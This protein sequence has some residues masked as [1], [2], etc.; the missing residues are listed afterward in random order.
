MAARR[1]GRGGSPKARRR[2][3]PPRA[4]GHR[5]HVQQLGAAAGAGAVHRLRRHRRRRCPAPAPRRC[6]VRQ[7]QPARWG[8]AARAAPRACW[9]A[10]PA[11]SQAPRPAR[12][13]VAQPPIGRLAAQRRRVARPGFATGEQGDG[14]RRR[15]AALR[16]AWSGLPPQQGHQ[17]QWGASG[18]L[19]PSV[20]C[21]GPQA[22]S[23]AGPTAERPSD[24]V[25]MT[26]RNTAL[27]GRYARQSARWARMRHEFARHPR[28]RPLPRAGRPG[29]RPWP[30]WGPTIKIERPGG[31]DDTRSW[32][33]PSWWATTAPNRTKAAYY[34]GANPQQALA[35]LRHRPA[36]RA[37]S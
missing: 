9:P 17:R 16:V 32:G 2:R 21:V 12:S 6:G 33:R 18:H 27:G 1:H 24:I 34:L 36:R 13:P 10:W 19:A 3:R 15:P 23:I 4:W 37:S 25:I 5:P 31:G 14:R 26:A 30:T 22:A 8:R 29:A 28:P 11:A 7:R 35:H 20:C